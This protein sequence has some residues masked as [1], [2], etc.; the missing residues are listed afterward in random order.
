[1]LFNCPAPDVP[2]EFKP[3]FNAEDELLEYLAAEYER[4]KA[5]SEPPNLNSS[6]RTTAATEQ[7]DQSSLVAPAVEVAQQKAA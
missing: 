6:D 3:L 1:M 5:S 2:D 7:E 4:R